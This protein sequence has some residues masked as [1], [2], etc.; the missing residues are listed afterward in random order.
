MAVTNK[1]AIETRAF[2]KQHGFFKQQVF[3][4]I[5]DHRSCIMVFGKH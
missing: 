4:F 5:Y 3:F 1:N 2:L